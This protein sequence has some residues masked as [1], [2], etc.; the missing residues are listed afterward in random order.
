MPKPGQPD[1][2]A[3]D[4]PSRVS[5]AAQRVEARQ[6]CGVEVFDEWDFA[7]MVPDPTC[8]PPAEVALP[9]DDPDWMPEKA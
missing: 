6:A 5:G 7:R 2:F 1:L 8:V 4:R 9:T 3:N